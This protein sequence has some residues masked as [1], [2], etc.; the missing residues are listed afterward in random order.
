MKWF[1]LFSLI[2]LVACSSSHEKIFVANEEGGSVSVIDARSLQEIDRVSLTLD[3]DEYLP[4]NVQVVGDRVL[5]TANGPHAHDEHEMDEEAA[6]S[7]GSS[8]HSMATENM[9]LPKGMIAV[10]AHETEES[11]ETHADQLVVLDARSNKIVERIDIAVG[12][13]LAHVV[14]Q[15]SIAYVTGTDADALY[16]VDL[17]AITVEK[18]SLPKGSMPHGM[19]LI[20]DKTA[21]IA[22]MGGVLLFVDLDSKEVMQVNLS[23]KGVQVGVVPGKVVV[24]IYDTKKLGVYDIA[25]RELKEFDLPNAMGPIQIYAAP[26]NKYF[27]VADQGAYFDRPSGFDVFKVN[28]E[29]GEIVKKS[30]VGQAPHGVVVSPDGRVW[31]TLL[32][33]DAVAVLKDDEKIASIPIGAAPNG[34]SYWQG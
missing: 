1:A 24:S 18:I 8:E 11:N 28:I 4:H 15:G 20:N 14:G 22:G 13:H 25:S 12:A 30:K 10:A 6:E 34:I 16:R 29:S 3:G 26:D 17:V 19:R 23:G 7:N 31:V 21:A 33:E 27:Y 9:P 32:Q 2:L 5:V